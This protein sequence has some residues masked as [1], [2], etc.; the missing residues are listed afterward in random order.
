MQKRGASLS[1]DTFTVTYDGEALA[2]HTMDVRDLAPA[3]MALS[4]LFQEAGRTLYGDESD[5]R[6]HATAMEQGCFAID[7][8]M[9]AN[10]AKQLKDLLNGDNM[11]A[12]L[13]LVELVGLGS[14]GGLGLLGL[15][16]KLRG[17]SPR[18]VKPIDRNMVRITMPDGLTI[19]VREQVSDLYRS[20]PVRQAVE[21]SLRPLQQDGIETVEFS[22]HGT[23]VEKIDKSEF[24][25][26]EAP[27]LGDE[28]VLEQV[29]TAAFT[30][31]SL[32]FNSSN[33]WRLFDG[34]KSFFAAIEDA[35]FLT[36][37]A[38]NQISFS[39]DD[40]LICEVRVTTKR[41]DGELKTDYVIEK[42]VEH[43]PAMQQIP[44]DINNEE[45]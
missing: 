1:K 32:A 22:R 42:V 33:K 6:I 2:S 18:V 13:N 9:I 37:V 26:Y 29:N 23:D 45:A 17:K 30:I 40:V 3:L 7:L 41:A 5:I 24:D 21:D 34:H 43:K 36:Q 35:D 14:A 15:I 16:R 25:L 27:S 20:H 8:T 4:T 12:G 11:Q 38:Q 28:V 39:K 10:H 31:S 44:F 19:D